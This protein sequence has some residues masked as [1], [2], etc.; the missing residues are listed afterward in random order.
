MLFIAESERKIFEASSGDANNPLRRTVHTYDIYDRVRHGSPMSVINHFFKVIPDTFQANS[1]IARVFYT[2]IERLNVPSEIMFDLVKRFD[3]GFGIDAPDHSPYDRIRK[4]LDRVP[5]GACR[6]L[7]KYLVGHINRALFATF[8]TE[9]R[10]TARI[11]FSS[12]DDLEQLLGI[13]CK[14]PIIETDS[15]RWFV[16]DLVNAS[17]TNALVGHA[18]VMFKPEN[19]PHFDRL[20]FS[21]VLPDEIPGVYPYRGMIPA[22]SSADY[23]AFVSRFR[24]RELENVTYIQ[25]L[26]SV[27]ITNILGNALS[28]IGTKPTHVAGQVPEMLLKYRIDWLKN[29]SANQALGTLDPEE[30]VPLYDAAADDETSYWKKVASVYNPI[31]FDEAVPLDQTL[32]SVQYKTRPEDY[33]AAFN[34]CTTMKGTSTLYLSKTHF[35]SIKTI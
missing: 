5:S 29:I 28:G 30:K 24:E 34:I 27:L 23:A 16:R 35:P 17:I 7:S 1:F 9:D 6:E 8:A 3:E 25:S 14:L 12:L 13:E 10:P 4:L 26:R 15:A 22:E 31:K 21:D 33:I 19:V 32:F 2:N 20:K 18:R 11:Q